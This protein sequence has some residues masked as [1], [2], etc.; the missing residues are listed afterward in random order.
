MVSLMRVRMEGMERCRRV[1]ALGL[2]F[3]HLVLPAW[4]KVARMPTSVQYSGGA[5]LCGDE[6]GD[7]DGLWRVIHRTFDSMQ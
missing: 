4:D 5:D 2:L 3:V 1:G 7:G 6:T